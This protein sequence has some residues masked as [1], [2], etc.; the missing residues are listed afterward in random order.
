[1]RNVGVGTVEKLFEQLKSMQ[2]EGSVLE[3]AK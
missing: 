1:M 2:Q 3:P